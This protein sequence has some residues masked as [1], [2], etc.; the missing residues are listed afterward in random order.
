MVCIENEIK[1]SHVKSEVWVEVPVVN[2][3]TDQQIDGLVYFVQVPHYL[4]KS[5][6]LFILY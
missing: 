3:V 2:K 4:L 5:I 6:Y 1:I